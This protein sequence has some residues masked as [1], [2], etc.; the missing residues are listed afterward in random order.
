MNLVERAE[1]PFEVGWAAAR[2]ADDDGL[3]AAMLAGLEAGDESPVQN[4][5]RGYFAARFRADGWPWA[6]TVLDADPFRSEEA[7]ARF[8]LCLPRHPDTWERVDAAGD[9]VG[10]EYWGRFRPGGLEDPT[11]ASQAASRLLEV[12]R[13][14]AAADLLGIYLRHEGVEY[15]SEL[16]VQA[17]EA[18]LG[19]PEAPVNNLDA[20]ALGQLLAAVQDTDAIPAERRAGLE[21]GYMPLLQHGLER[22]KLLHAELSREPRFFVE[23]VSLVYRPASVEDHEEV[24][25]DIVRRAQLAYDLL[26]SWHTPPGQSPDTL[27]IDV[28]REWVGEARNLL[29]EA[30]REAVGDIQIG[31][32]LRYTRSAPDGMWPI[33][34]VRQLIEELRSEEVERG[35]ETEIFNSRGVTTRPA[36]AGGDSER[37]ISEKYDRHAAAAED[38]WPH[39]AALLRRVARSF[40][41]EARYVD[42]RAAQWE[43]FGD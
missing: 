34:G 23:V 25:E 9:R 43:D 20:Y 39:T 10:V 2:F 37:V 40:E 16:L 14:L 38:R 31:K 22:P 11:S 4:A 3:D 6:S 17:L 33:E 21:W 12:R 28:L 13:P 35:I 42:Q 29:R 18:V 32:I 27:D 5:A 15:S 1:I 19:E 24:A 26:D 7:L 41:R 30:D 36:G 8:F